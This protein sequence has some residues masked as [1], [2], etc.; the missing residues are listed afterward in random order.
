VLRHIDRRRFQIDF[1]VPSSDPCDFDDEI[2]SLGAQLFPCLPPRPPWWCPHSV[3]RGLKRRLGVPERS[4]EYLLHY[5]RFLRACLRE[6]GPYDVVHSQMDAFSGFVLGVAV[7]IAHSHNDVRNWDSSASLPRRFYLRLMNRWI[8]RYA[9]CRLACS[10]QAGMSLFGADGDRPGWQVLHNGV[11]LEPFE[12]S[13][14]R[15]SFRTELGL[16]PEARVLGH[17]GRFYAQ[18]NHHFLLEILAELARRDPNVYLLLIGDGPLRPD[19]EREA[20]RR[21]LQDR[22]VF[23]GVRSDV[24]RLMLAAMDVFVL[25]SHYE[26]NPLVGAEAQAAGLPCLLSDV[27]TSEVDLVGGLIRRLPLGD[28]ALWANAIADTLRQPR[29]VS[30]ADALRIVQQSPL[31]IRKAVQALEHVYQEAHA[32]AR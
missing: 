32:H 23:A 31:N 7:R 25:P 13:V 14:D 15:E 12:Q 17:V 5:G 18:K 19:V 10:G 3:Q 4:P 30:H 28:A 24:P 21:S 20:A 9:T 29:A 11:D 6:H 8:D 1:L 22:I 27:I 16:P 26:G 2:R